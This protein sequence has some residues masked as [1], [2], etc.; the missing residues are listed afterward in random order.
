M[1]K[2]L[3]PTNFSDAS[4]NAFL[5]AL[6]LAKSIDAEILTLHVY[7]LPLVDYMDVPVYLLDIYEVT[8]LSNFQNYRHNIPVLR[9]IAEK[10][11]LEDI[12][13]SNVLES[14]NLIDNIQKITSEQNIDYIVMG[15]KSSDGFSTAFLG[16][17]AEKVMHQAH[18]IVLA[19][20]EN[21]EFEKPKKILFITRF[22]PA[23]RE[24]LKNVLAMA[25]LFQSSVDCL[26]VRNT[27]D[28]I[29]DH[30]IDDWRE[31]L[32][33]DQVTYHTLLGNDVEHTILD[34][35]D[36]HHTDILAMP[37]HDRGFFEGLFHVSLSKKLTS[38]VRIPILSLHE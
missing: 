7:E 29:D 24:L 19:I 6:Q 12:K 33:Q 20:P 17:V 31:V 8:E 27:S 28:T 23:D 18:T 36:D 13:I 1:K 4:N 26:Y 9:E 16:S 5:Y 3:F 22:Q 30:I 34:F 35:I 10:H 38:H 25:R 32:E 15:T 2:I 37:I 21:C 11:H 14:G